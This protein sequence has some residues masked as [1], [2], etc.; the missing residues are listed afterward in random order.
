ME[1]ALLPGI[2]L[3]HGFETASGL[4]VGGFEDVRA[5][6]PEECGELIA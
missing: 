6:P 4:R 3:R 2:G 1:E 5:Q